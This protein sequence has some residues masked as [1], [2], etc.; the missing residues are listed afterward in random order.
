MFV[1]L[2]FTLASNVKVLKPF[3]YHCP[4]LATTCWQ[5]CENVLCEFGENNVG[6]RLMRVVWNLLEWKSAS[7]S[8]DSTL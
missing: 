1:V 3:S 2:L 5:C 4:E 8:T 7:F 6:A